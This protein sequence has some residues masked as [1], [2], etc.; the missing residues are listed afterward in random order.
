[1]NGLQA[2]TPYSGRPVV[3]IPEFIPLYNSLNTDILHSLSFHCIL[4]RFVIDGEGT[5]EEERK[6]RFSFSTPKH[7]TRGIKRI[8]ES[9]MGTPPSAMIIEDVYLG[10]KA[11]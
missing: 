1:M 10:F 4:R 5:D 8:W 11:L 7:F 3:N 6:M 9:K 2:R